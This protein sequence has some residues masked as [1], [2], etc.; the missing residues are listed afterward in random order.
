MSDSIAS[1][2]APRDWYK[3]YRKADKI[4]MYRSAGRWDR[5][6]IMRDSVEHY[7]VY[8]LLCSDRRYYTGITNNLARRMLEHEEGIDPTCYTFKRRPVELVYNH[9]FREVTDA[10]R[11]EKQI[12]GWSRRK[13]EALIRGKVELLPVLARR[14]TPFRKDRVVLRDGP[15]VSS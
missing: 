8:I 14:Q 12:K 9:S 1:A 13:K 10:I 2:Q 6:I 11:A 5:L 3:A 15:A 7:F 4:S